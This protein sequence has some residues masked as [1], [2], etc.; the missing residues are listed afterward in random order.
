VIWGQ[1]VAFRLLSYLPDRR[2]TRIEQS[3]HIIARGLDASRAPY[4]ESLSTLSVSCH[5][6]RYFSRNNVLR[7][8]SAT[9]EVVRGDG[10]GARLSVEARVLSVK[11][12]GADEKLFDVAMELVSPQNIWGVVHPPEDWSEFAEV[13]GPVENVRELRVVPRSDLRVAPE[14]ATVGPTG[15]SLQTARSTPP[16]LVHHAAS[17][18]EQAGGDA[19]TSDKSAACEGTQQYVRGICSRVESDAA[20]ELESLVASFAAEI[21]RRVQQLSDDREA[22]AR[23]T[24][25]RLLRKFELELANRRL[26]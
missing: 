24:Y 16:F 14:P 7:G 8:D 2:S 23:I 20:R 21:N 18:R 9:I 25:E 15:A 26:A 11:P 12:L 3:V 10:A 1:I 13:A 17:L 6:C 22:A 5:G 19:L 4:Q